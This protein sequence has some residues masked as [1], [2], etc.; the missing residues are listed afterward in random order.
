MKRGKFIGEMFAVASFMAYM[1]MPMATYAQSTS[2]GNTV[3]Y[4]V[5]PEAKRQVNEGWGVSLC[6]WA[7]M[8]GKWS[9]AK[10]DQLV[11]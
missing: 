8:C 4:V 3:S 11:E 5:N 2:S 1:F 10:I 7:N 6:W 9:D